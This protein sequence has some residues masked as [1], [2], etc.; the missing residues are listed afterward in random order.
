MKKPSRK[1]IG[2]MILLGAFAVAIISKDALENKALAKKN[3][4]G[5]STIEPVEM[6]KNKSIGEY[7]SDKF[8]EAKKINTASDQ[9]KD[10][11]V[12]D[13]V[14]TQ[15]F[16]RYNK[17]KSQSLD[18]SEN[19]EFLTSDI[20]KQTKDFAKIP[21]K[22]SFLTLKTFPNYQK[23]K[24][25]KYGEDFANI[26]EKYYR[27]QFFIENYGDDAKFIQEYVDIQI[28]FAEELSSIETPRN[29]SNEHLEFTN[30]TVRIGIAIITLSEIENDPFLSA[31][32]LNQYNEIKI[33]QIEILKKVSEYFKIND[34]IFN[35]SDKGIWWN[36]I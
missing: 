35:D 19:I 34:I 31:V 18:T 1:V 7:I 8:E 26:N 30:N 32:V 15:L 23:D 29:I 28:K 27:Q 22:Y 5:E 2:T 16:N 13:S 3:N 14:I 11:T 9:P 12:T 36:T 10:L 33:R 4:R 17:L 20:A 24:I 21:D 25:K 6:S